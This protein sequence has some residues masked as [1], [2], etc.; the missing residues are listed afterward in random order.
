M[1]KLN[2]IDPRVGGCAAYQSRSGTS[3]AAEEGTQLH[4]LVEG[5]I[6]R[7]AKAGRPDSLVR[8]GQVARTWDDTSAPLL[9]YCFG[10]VDARVH[11]KARLFVEPMVELKNHDGKQINFGSADLIALQPGGTKGV[12]MDWKFGQIPVLPAEMNRQG[13]GYAA[14]L[15]Q[16]VPQLEEVEVVFVQPRLGY[17]TSHVFRRTD[18]ARLIALVRDLIAHAMDASAVMHR[19]GAKP[20][21]EETAYWTNPGPACEYCDAKGSCAGWLR[22]W[23]RGVV[24]MGGLPL[25]LNINLDS[26]D[27]PE[28]AAIAHAWLKF[29]EGAS[30]LISKRAKE[31][32]RENGGEISATLPSG[33]VIRYKLGAR[34]IPRTLG[35]TLEIVELAKQW[36]SP[37]QLLVAAEF[38][39]GKLTEIL[40][41]SWLDF[42]PGKTKKEAIEVIEDTL[43]AAG[44]LTQPDGR[45]EYLQAVKEKSKALKK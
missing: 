30:E 20:S 18:L 24:A 22:Q 4:E 7:W 40:A 35:N 41:A 6:R 28:K 12:L 19:Q 17:T 31:I 13:M 10:A 27:T 1:S 8:F 2:S 29:L 5:V 11:P 43:T 9:H 32:A 42:N 36:C 15:M 33:D 26:I 45:I 14:A 38:S 16:R 21:D 37:E 44:L 34:S 39:L 23:Q 25:P 3:A